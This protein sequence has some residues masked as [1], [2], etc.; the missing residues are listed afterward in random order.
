MPRPSGM[1]SL[2]LAVW[3]EMKKAQ[4]LGRSWKYLTTCE[5]HHLRMITIIIGAIRATEIE[6]NDQVRKH[7]IIADA[8]KMVAQF[9][10]DWVG[11]GRSRRM[12][13][14][15]HRGEFEIDIKRDLAP[16]SHIHETLG[17]IGCNTSPLGAG[18]RILV[19]H[20]HLVLDA[21]AVADAGDVDGEMWTNKVRDIMLTTWPG[22]R[23]TQAKALYAKQTVL[24]AV[25]KIYGYCK[26]RRYEYSTGGYGDVPTKYVAPYEWIWRRLLIKIYAS[27]KTEFRSKK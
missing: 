9:R 27:T 2:S 26:K 16:G 17:S 5:K 1:G 10:A 12:V 3:I 13:G 20:V 23:R 15:T 6:I 8:I 4:G 7:E 25:R 11:L 24:V 21:T 19:I 14:F 18:E 22:T